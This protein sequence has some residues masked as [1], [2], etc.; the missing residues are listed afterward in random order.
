MWRNAFEF[1]IFPHFIYE[2]PD[3]LAALPKPTPVDIKGS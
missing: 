2:G 3:I 1:Y